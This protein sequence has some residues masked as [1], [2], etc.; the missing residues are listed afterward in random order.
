MSRRPPVFPTG[1]KEI[2]VIDA[3]NKCVG[4][5][6]AYIA[7]QLLAGVKVYVINVEKSMF[8]GG[9]R[10]VEKFREKMKIRSYIHPN[11]TPRHPTTPI[12]IFRR[13]VRGMLPIRKPKGIAA[14]RRL[15]IFVGSPPHLAPYAEHPLPELDPLSLRKYITVG[16]LSKILRGGKTFVDN[17]KIRESLRR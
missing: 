15:R 11:N 14:Y 3:T 9:E 8:L 17:L 12:E 6:A 5:L 13:V 10:T 4:R 7:K 1:E 2:K 16:D